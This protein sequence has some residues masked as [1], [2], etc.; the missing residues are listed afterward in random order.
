VSEPDKRK[1][2]LIFSDDERRQIV[3]NFIEAYLA[4]EV[5]I[6]WISDK[7]YDEFKKKRG[8]TGYP[9]AIEYR[10]WRKETLHEW[11]MQVTGYKQATCD[12]LEHAIAEI[13]GF[14]M[15]N[16]IGDRIKGSFFKGT[17]TEQRMKDLED[18]VASHGRLI[19][20]LRMLGHVE[21]NDN[22]NLPQV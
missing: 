18:K 16:R 8:L 13:F 2:H 4:N 21:G 9:S 14:I 1:P 17:I 6:Q 10:L 15:M 12:E 19:Q 20:D 7:H 3:R 22:E 11:I 5:E